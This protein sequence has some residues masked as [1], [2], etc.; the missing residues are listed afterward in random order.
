M[1]GRSAIWPPRSP[2]RPIK[3]IPHG[4]VAEPEYAAPLKGFG[5]PD[6]LAEGIAGWDAAASQEGLFDESHELSKLIGRPTT[7]LT[8]PVADA[9]GA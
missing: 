6:D 7:P 4:D 3:T 2:A 9:L 8:V 1:P 5:L